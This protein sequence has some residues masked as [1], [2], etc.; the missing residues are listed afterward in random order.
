M[1]RLLTLALAAMLGLAAPAIAG[2]TASDSDQ[3]VDSSDQPFDESDEESDD[4]AE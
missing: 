1:N 3:S 4:D 2:T